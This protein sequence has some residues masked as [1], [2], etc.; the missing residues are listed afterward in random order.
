MKNTYF[1]NKHFSSLTPLHTILCSRRRRRQ[2]AMTTRI[3]IDCKEPEAKNIHAVLQQAGISC[4]VEDMPVGDFA[5][6]VESADGS[7]QQVLLMERKTFSDLDASIKD[8]RYGVQFELMLRSEAPL[9]MYCFGGNMDWA[10]PPGSSKTQKRVLRTLNAQMHITVAHRGR[11]SNVFYYKEAHLPLML[12]KLLFYLR[13]EGYLAEAGEVEATPASGRKRK[14]PQQ[15]TLSKAAAGTLEHNIRVAR[16]Q[17][18]LQPDV[19]RQQLLAI[20]GLRATAA[21]AIIK[22]Y[23]S[24]FSL[25][26]ALLQRGAEE[27][28]KNID[29][30]GK[31]TRAKIYTAF[32]AET[33]RASMTEVV[34]TAMQGEGLFFFSQE[35]TVQS[36]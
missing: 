25:C 30:V 32:I 33:D 15:S 17:L 11:V 3:I 13:E 29:G 12:V 34:S 22:R 35:D 8:G 19:Y 6:V 20:H 10:G 27:A 24:V 26:L 5:I 31:A 36:D 2:A 16:R 21:D 9:L 14:R 28:L 4:C 7:R 1:L 23:S 18:L